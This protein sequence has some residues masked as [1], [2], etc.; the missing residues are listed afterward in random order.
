MD[1]F[2]FFDLGNLYLLITPLIFEVISQRCVLIAATVLLIWG[3]VICIVGAT[4]FL[5]Y[6][7]FVYSAGSI[8]FCIF[9]KFLSAAYKKI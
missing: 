4:F 9:F 7:S 2:L 8:A 3:G 1:L 6:C 5:C